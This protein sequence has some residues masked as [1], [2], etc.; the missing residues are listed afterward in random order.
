MQQAND[1]GY[2]DERAAAVRQIIAARR[3][4]EQILGASLFADPAWDM[5]LEL[6][7]CTLEQRRLTVTDISSAAVVPV[8]TALRW[9]AKLLNDG[10]AAR[11]GDPL[12]AR[13]SWVELTQHGR[14]AMDRVVSSMPLGGPI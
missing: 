6:Y 3:T 13:R 1:N 10:L 5:L 14:S 4:R 8:S 2:P 9:L 12:D 11:R 7:A